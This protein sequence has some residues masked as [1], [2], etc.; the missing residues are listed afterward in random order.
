M[1]SA[2]I[3]GFNFASHFTKRTAKPASLVVERRE[4]STVDATSG[5]SH[6]ANKDCR[7]CVRKESS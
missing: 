1:V 3:G 2:Q 7:Y 6:S 4:P 5:L